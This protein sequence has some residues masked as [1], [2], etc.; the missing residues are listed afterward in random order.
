M[1]TDDDDIEKDDDIERDNDDYDVERDKT[2]TWNAFNKLRNIVSENKDIEDAPKILEEIQKDWDTFDVLIRKCTIVID[3]L[4]CS[5]SS[6]SKEKERGKKHEKL[7][8]DF[9]KVKKNTLEWKSRFA[10]ELSVNK[11]RIDQAHMETRNLQVNVRKLR[12]QIEEEQKNGAEKKKIHRKTKTILDAIIRWGVQMKELINPMSQWSDI[13]DEIDPLRNEWKNLASSCAELRAEVKSEIEES[14]QRR[15][16]G[17]RTF[18][19]K[20]TRHIEMI[21]RDTIRAC[22]KKKINLKYLYG[23][24]S[25]GTLFELY[26][27]FLNNFCFFVVCT[28]RWTTIP[29]EYEMLQDLAKFFENQSLFKEG[30]K[31]IDR[32]VWELRKEK[33]MSE[34]NTLK[35]MATNCNN[36]INRIKQKYE[37]VELQHELEIL[38]PDYT[39]QQIFDDFLTHSNNVMKDC[40]DLSQ[41]IASIWELCLTGKTV[42]Q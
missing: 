10:K 22:R 21:L 19:T 4:E 25:K 11:T 12:E 30:P 40:E 9:S 20:W 23:N 26:F 2:N 24:R 17:L 18:I 36:D 7:K 15:L 5:W 31:S 34:V 16:H 42:K 38:F 1:M 35:N 32:N 3:K 41:H 37:D 28:D 8:N 13:I 14:K 33:I 27:F 6:S 39:N 29:N